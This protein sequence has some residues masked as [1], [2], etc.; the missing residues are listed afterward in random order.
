[1][2]LKVVVPTFNAARWIRTCLLSIVRQRFRDFT[3]LVIDDA[4]QDDTWNIIQ[5]LDFLDERFLMMR[6]STNL[7]PLAN[8]YNGFERLGC[9]RDPESVL[10]IVD[11]DDRLAHDGAFG[12]VEKAYAG[13]SN[14][15]MTYGNYANDTEPSVGKCGEFPESVIS[16]R[17]FRNHLACVSCLRTFKA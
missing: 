3:C 7:G 15:L 5:S 2:D 13:D 11:G 12:V 8:T 14:L 6:N 1:M 17:N 10:T 16:G 9:R 4:S